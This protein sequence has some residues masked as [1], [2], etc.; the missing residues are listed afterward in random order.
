M[1]QALKILLFFKVFILR[2]A[3]VLSWEIC[4]P[5]PWSVQG[6][7]SPP[8]SP[9]EGGGPHCPDGHR[10]LPNTHQP[11]CC[12]LVPLARHSTQTGAQLG[13]KGIC[14]DLPSRLSE[15]RGGMGSS[16]PVLSWEQNQTEILSCHRQ[17][18]TILQ[19]FCH[20]KKKKGRYF[21]IYLL[22]R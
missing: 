20:L 10:V 14:L 16:T 17:E 22:L 5:R 7:V 1:N 2:R 11:S 8:L 3:K 15:E 12:L 6:V 9:R 21:F 19:V 4:Q 18:M 13:G